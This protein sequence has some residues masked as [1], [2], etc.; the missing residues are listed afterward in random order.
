[1]P[2]PDR[3]PP[4]WRLFIGGLTLALAG[5]APLVALELLYTLLLLQ[6][7]FHDADLVLFAVSLSLTLLGAAAALG[8][9]E[10]LVAVILAWHVRRWR[11]RRLGP[12]CWA[13]ALA[14][15][16]ASPLLAWAAVVLFSGRA[17]RELPGHDLIVAGVVILGTALVWGVAVLL[18]WLRA[19]LRRQGGGGRATVSTL[20]LAG[21]GTLLYVVDHRVFP[22]LYSGLHGVLAVG[23]F[24]SFQ[25]AM[26][27]LATRWTLPGASRRLW[28][29]T[30]I[31]CGACL[32]G[33]AWGAQALKTSPS[34]RYLAVEHTAIQRKLVI[35]ARRLGLEL[36][37]EHIPAAVTEDSPTVEQALRPGPRLPGANLV[38]ITVDALRA[39]HMGVYGHGRHT[40]PNIDAW[41]RRATVFERAYCPT[42]HTSFSLTS[43]LTGRHMY[44][45]TGGEHATSADV[46]RRHG[47]RTAAFFPPAVFFVDRN[48]FASF[49][50]RRFGFEHVVYDRADAQRRVDQA[51]TF[52]RLAPRGKPFFIW[53]HLF[54]PHE[55]YRRHPRH[56]FGPRA[57]DRYDSEIAHVDRHLGR[58][59]A[60]LSRDHPRNAVALTADHGE[61]FGEHG[62]HYHGSALYEEQIRVPAVVMVPGVQARRVRGAVHSLDLPVT[63]LALAGVPIPSH[64]RGT[65]LGPYLMGEPPQSLPPVFSEIRSKKAVIDGNLK[66]IHD[67]TFSFSELY[68]LERDPK[69]LRNLA[70]RMPEVVATLRGKMLRWLGATAETLDDP[71]L[72]HRL[73][74]RARNRDR[75]AIPALEELTR[76]GAPHVR[77]EAVRLLVELRARTALEDLVDAREDPDPQLRTDATIGAALAGHSESLADVRRMLQTGTLTSMRRRSALLA[78]AAAGDRTVAAELAHMLREEDDLFERNELIRVLGRLGDPVASD[79]LRRQLTTF[80]TRRHAMQAL[81]R[82]RDRGSVPLLVAALTRDAYVNWRSTAAEALGRIG[83]RSAVPALQGAVLGEIEP[84]VVTVALKSLDRLRGL[85]VPGTHGLRRPA[86]WTC[87]R[88]W[89]QLR[90]GMRCQ[91]GQELMLVLAHPP[92]SG[93]V[94]RCGTWQ[95]HVSPVLDQE[96][97]EWATVIPLDADGALVLEAGEPIRHLA[98]RQP[99]A[100]A[101][102]K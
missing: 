90:S 59:L 75:G 73:L 68:D 48:R 44:A 77:R 100:V 47:Y 24:A 91:R 36:E 85:P 18:L 84:A 38:L 74:E 69:E 83:D 45:V 99:P 52:L 8:L 13:S 102:I 50:N 79:A 2:G 49:E 64:E 56:D 7:V 67:T 3:Q 14:A 26:M 21:L 92:Q 16:G 58:L 78:L 81:G 32:L 80:R 93:L 10:G 63:L 72:V 53:L 20:A 88:K 70:G 22:G 23:A 57:I 65:D 42:P 15:L 35:L 17:A 87:R 86:R 98:V 12:R 76:R 62:L 39:D 5:A 97:T 40:T 34:L 101:G 82:V 27:M 55:P 43:I 30:P 46:L 51:I 37:I 28:W 19:H 31:L 1:M 94:I 9:V 29:I 61:A 66:L 96:R 6:P 89:C 54:D 41:A 95:T 60:C 33:G 11:P 25:A 4:V 71:R